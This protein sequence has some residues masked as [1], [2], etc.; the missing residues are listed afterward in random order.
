[1]LQKPGTKANISSPNLFLWTFK[2]G[3]YGW[4]AYPKQCIDHRRLIQK[5]NKNKQQNHKQIESSF[6]TLHI[7]FLFKSHV[8]VI[9][10]LCS[11][12]FPNSSKIPFPTHLYAHILCLPPSLLLSFLGVGKMWP[13]LL[14]GHALPAC[15]HAFWPVVIPSL[16]LPMP[17]S[18]G[19]LPFF[20]GGDR[21]QVF[22]N[23]EVEQT[24]F[25][26]SYF[27]LV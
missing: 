13:A 26:W 24:L 7:I 3:L 18:L 15:S 6:Q 25:A 4:S 22:W 19:L 17:S 12:P 5:T 14:L 16:P 8:H 9:F 27:L 21:F 1:M 2:M 20:P 10:L 11:F 23:C